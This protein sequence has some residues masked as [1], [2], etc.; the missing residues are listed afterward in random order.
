MV[1]IF[2]PTNTIFGG[3]LATAAGLNRDDGFY[4]VW[5]ARH[6]LYGNFREIPLLYPA[7]VYTYPF[8]FDQCF[9]H[10]VFGRE[11]MEWQLWRRYGIT[12]T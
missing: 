6:R 10:H 2:Q 5:V 7:R 12:I 9:S 8:L 1:N 4:W 3:P 11:W